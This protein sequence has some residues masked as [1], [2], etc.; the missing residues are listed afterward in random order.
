MT[1]LS[2]P[3][4]LGTWLT[5]AISATAKTPRRQETGSGIGRQ[6]HIDDGADEHQIDAAEGDL[7]RGGLCGVEGR[8]IDASSRCG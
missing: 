6:E 2:T 1:G 5:T 3:M 4:P 7:G 8:W